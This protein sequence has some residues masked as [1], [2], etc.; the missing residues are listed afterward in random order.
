M[1]TK[2]EGGKSYPAKS[3]LVVGDKEQPSTWH[4]RVRDENGAPDHRVMGAAWAALHSGFR[5]NKYE[6]SQK[7]QAIERLKKLYLAED[8]PLPD[9]TKSES[10]QD[11]IDNIRS[12]FYGSINPSPSN[13]NFYVDEVYPD[14]VIA[15]DVNSG[16]KYQ[17][18]FTENADGI[19]FE[20]KDN[21]IEVEEEYVPVK[22]EDMLSC[23]GAEV[24]AL[25]EGKVGGYLIIYGDEKNA[26]ISSMRDFFQSDTDFGTAT[27]STILYHHGLDEKIGTKSLGQ[28]SI[29]KD[30]V[31]IWI[32]SQLEMR[33][34]YEKAIYGLAEKGKLGWSS[35]TA[36]HLVRRKK[37]GN[38][39]KILS[40]PLG[41][42]ASLTPR[43]AEPRTN[44]IAIKSLEK[45][46]FVIEPVSAQEIKERKQ[47]MENQD[48]EV[49][50]VTSPAITSA[51]VQAIL[52]QTLAT[53]A[54]EQEAAQ[55]KQKDVEALTETIHELVSS[56]MKST[57][58]NNGGASQSASVLRKTKRGDDAFKAFAYFIKTGDSK[59][60]RTG[61]AYE[62]WQR[63]QEF[64]MKTDYPMLESTQYQGQEAVPTEVLAV[65]HEKRNAISV[66]RAAGATVYPAKSNAAVIP[67][68]KAIPQK[69]G[70]TSIDNSN[71][72]TTQT[73]QPLDKLAAT[74]YM[75]TYNI[76]V[77]INLIDD[78]V[79]NV[80]GWLSRRVGRGAGLTENQYFLMGTGSG[81]P[82]GAAYGSTLGVTSASASVFTAAEI[83]DQYYKLAGEYRDN[84]TWVMRGTTEGGIRKLTSST[85]PFIGTGGTQG[86]LGT[87]FGTNALN[88]GTGW[89]VDPKARVFNSDEMDA[90][91]TT[92]KPVLLGNFEAGYAIIERKMLTV[93]R[94]PYSSASKGIVQLWWYMREG[95][96]IVDTA[97][98]Y[99]ILTPSA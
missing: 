97:A 6:G 43:P 51:D 35:G 60:I 41:L 18:N 50:S 3:Y 76:P 37:I 56:V 69:F 12:S 99:H 89:L 92:K 24:K 73:S 93:L 28:G 94:D 20:P 98:L 45:T 71:T 31:G 49:K 84:P 11:Q 26:D 17:V 47:V 27:T 54:A 39:H 72:F 85:L 1:A 87:G 66:A 65:I 14:Y 68:E 44:V 70:I 79:F 16:K 21:W 77:D 82:Q 96:G 55:K 22:S 52:E 34:D 10:L 9:E 46:K 40:W 86:A 4:L 30:E 19:S 80:E 78:S 38:A 58:A 75:F 8:L 61:Q 64:E 90:V 29:R 57:P 32:E 33:D 36:P 95:G 2:T 88:A 42:D 63:Q 62:E 5:G 48:P 81:Q 53:K 7:S 15:C 67:V 83:I 59:P 25:G 91:S 74:I 13:A 23:Y